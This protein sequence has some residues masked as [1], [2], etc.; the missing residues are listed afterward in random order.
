MKITKFRI[1]LGVI[2]ILTASIA[3]SQISNPNKQTPLFKKTLTLR[4]YY[5]ISRWNMAVLQSKDNRYILISQKND[6]SL[7]RKNMMKLTKDQ[8]ISITIERYDHP[9]KT[10][11]TGVIGYPGKIACDVDGISIEIDVSSTG[12][13]Y[14]SP[15]L[16]FRNNNVYLWQ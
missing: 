1:V 8:V 4:S 11:I 9:D 6:N 10:A 16:I 5:K 3:C 14:Y 2:L 13:V 7:I 15:D 12:N